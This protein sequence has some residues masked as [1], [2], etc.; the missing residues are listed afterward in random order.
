MQLTQFTDNGLRT[1]I[2]LASFPE[3][4]LTIDDIHRVF[5]MSR[6][7]LAKVVF[8]LNQLGFIQSTRGKNGG[9]ELA[10]KPEDISIGEVVRALEPHF[11]LL[12]CFNSETNTCPL[13]GPC[14]LQH[15]LTKARDA[16]LAQLDE[17]TLADMSRGHRRH[18]D[19]LI[20]QQEGKAKV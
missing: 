12:E 2:Q 19:N 20:A 15:A 3:R 13:A 4:R 5:R 14:R 7:H 16:F 18:F 8:R 11:D 17:L 6:P 9:I 1:L 10:Q